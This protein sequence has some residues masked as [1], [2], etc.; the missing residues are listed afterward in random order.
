M[1]GH[2]T[3]HT[4]RVCRGTSQNIKA[5]K[6]A[7]SDLDSEFTNST[8]ASK[9]IRPAQFNKRRTELHF[10]VEECQGHTAE[11]VV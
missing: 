7:S 9:S 1:R 11:C 10:L 3:H 4:G 2:L 5:E 8:V 6:I